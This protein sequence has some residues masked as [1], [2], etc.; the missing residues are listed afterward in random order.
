[1]FLSF[2]FVQEVVMSVVDDKEYQK[3][4]RCLVDPTRRSP[5]GPYRYAYS[6][7]QFERRIRDEAALPLR[8]DLIRASSPLDDDLL[9]GQTRDLLE[10]LGLSARQLQVCRLRME[11]WTAGEIAQKIGITERRVWGIL[12]EVKEILKIRLGRSGTV[13]EPDDP[14]YGWQEVFLDS[15]RRRGQE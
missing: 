15:Q 6:E 8:D 10:G 14:Y 1:M 7:E 4:L 11:E 3:T 12:K 13:G 2:R 5:R 9:N